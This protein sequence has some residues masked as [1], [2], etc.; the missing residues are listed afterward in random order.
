MSTNLANAS[1]FESKSEFAL[2]SGPTD[3]GYTNEHYRKQ[4]ARLEHQNKFLHAELVDAL[5]HVK[6]MRKE[7]DEAMRARQQDAQEIGRLTSLV[8]ELSGRVVTVEQRVE[9]ASEQFAL[10]K[11]QIGKPV[12]A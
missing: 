7:L 11:K 10:I 2:P 4:F 6:M 12:T 5:H 8:D 3:N 9:K 1:P